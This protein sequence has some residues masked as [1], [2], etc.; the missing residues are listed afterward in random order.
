MTLCLKEFGGNRIE[1]RYEDPS[2][3]R[4]HRGVPRLAKWGVLE[5]GMSESK[6]ETVV[7]V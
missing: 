6:G 3:S 7:S 4:E 5:T 1:A 2:P